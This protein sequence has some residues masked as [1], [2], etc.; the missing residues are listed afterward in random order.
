MGDP[1][2]QP[3]RIL[4]AP[5]NI[6]NQTSDIV[7]ALCRAGHHAEVWESTPNP[8]GP[9]TGPSLPLDPADSHGTLPG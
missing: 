9:S 5:R 7:A 3:L 1:G 2:A 6:A 4:H 8:F